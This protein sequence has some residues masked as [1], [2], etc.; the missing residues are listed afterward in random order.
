M[1]FNLNAY[2]AGILAL[3]KMI[4]LIFVLIITIVTL[5]ICYLLIGFEFM[6]KPLNKL[7][8]L[9]ESIIDL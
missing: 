8:D 4:L 2:K 6:Q 1:K 5:I 7:G 3:I 9:L